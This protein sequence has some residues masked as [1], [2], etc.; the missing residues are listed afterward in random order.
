M[1][2]NEIFWLERQLWGWVTRPSSFLNHACSAACFVQEILLS[3]LLLHVIKQDCQRGPAVGLDKM[4][5]DEDL[6]PASL[7]FPHS[8][9]AVP[10]PEPPFPVW[11]A[12]RLHA[13]L[14]QTL[15]PHRALPRSLLPAC[16]PRKR[17]TGGGN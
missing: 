3:D 1:C 14:G 10:R 17:S 16:Q 12:D 6:G 13:R 7:S 2:Q 11:E 15:C 5:S 9:V 4:S 8:S